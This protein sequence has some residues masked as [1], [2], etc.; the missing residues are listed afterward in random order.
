MDYQRIGIYRL[1]EL[2]RQRHP[3]HTEEAPRAFVLCILD[4]EVVK[5]G[6]PAIC[7]ICPLTIQGLKHHFSGRHTLMNI[8]GP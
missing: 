8:V 1:R 4:M 2:M 3:E 6:Y 7:T 5:Q